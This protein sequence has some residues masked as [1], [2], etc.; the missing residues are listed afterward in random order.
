MSDDGVRL[1]LDGRLLID[2]WTEHGPQMDS[3]NRVHLEEEKTYDIRLEYF[4]GPGGSV[5]RLYWT[6]PSMSAAGDAFAK[7]ILERVKNDGT[8]VLFIDGTERW[9][10]YMAGAGIVKYNGRMDVGSVWYGGNLFVREHPLFKDLPVNQGLNWEY[11]DLEYYGAQRYGLMLEGEEA[12]AGT[13]NAH[14]PRVGTAVAVLE[15]GKGRIVLSTLDIV[16][17]LNGNSSGTNV[18]RKIFCN[19]LEYAGKS[20]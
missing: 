7:S 15:Y 20:Q 8:T 9:T 16:R 17:R 19:Y 13:V 1:W 5:I 3:S 4:Q 2:N 14:E 12:V 10:R 11:Q 18:V 6:L